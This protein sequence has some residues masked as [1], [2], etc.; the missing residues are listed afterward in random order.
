MVAQT[1]RGVLFVH[2]AP[3]ALC[4]HLE[5]AAGRAL[6][7]AVNFDWIEQPVLRGSQRAEFTWEGP[8]GTG[9]MIASALRGWEQ[10]RYEVTED[11]ALGVDGGRWMHTPELGV[12]YA[13]T[14]SVG[15]TVVPENRIRDAIE[16]AGADAIALHRELRLALGQAWED[17]LEPFRYGGDFAP[18]VWLHRVG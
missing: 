17:E 5:W 12:F 18:V 4:P 16:S 7:R 9:A 14:D 1:T 8:V 11:P 6:G 10:L 2:S 13:Q 3:R 15:N